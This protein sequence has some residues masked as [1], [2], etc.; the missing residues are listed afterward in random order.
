MLIQLSYEGITI[1]KKEKKV[2][3]ERPAKAGEEK[4]ITRF[5]RR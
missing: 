4:L 1:R 3:K 5:Q 2:L